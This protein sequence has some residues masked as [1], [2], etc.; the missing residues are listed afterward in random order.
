ML[1]KNIEDA[2]I[3]PKS[4]RSVQVCGFRTKVYPPDKTEA[5][6]YH[7]AC[8]KLSLQP[9]AALSFFSGGLHEPQANMKQSSL[10]ATLGLVNGEAG[11]DKD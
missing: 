7:H 11:R 4:M 5:W 3:S 2:Q 8:D 6:L 9:T 10:F 1:V